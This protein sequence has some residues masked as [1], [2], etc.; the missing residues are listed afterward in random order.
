MIRFALKCANGHGFESWFASSEKFTDLVSRGLVTCPECDCAEVSKD[1]MA[2]PVRASRKKAAREAARDET[3]RPM[4]AGPDPE[5]A[6]AI[7]KLK[8]HVEENSDY[9]GDRFVTEARAMHEGTLPQRSIHGEA[10]SDEARKLIEDGVPA[11]PL[12]FM[13]RQKT[14]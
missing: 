4:V 3:P 11:L 13:P 12:P 7:R 2:P 6:D 14:N 5:I 10:R 9:V 1:L 8:A